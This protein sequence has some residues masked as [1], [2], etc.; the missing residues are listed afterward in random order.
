MRTVSMAAC[1]GMLWVILGGGVYASDS[2]QYWNA[3]AFDYTMNENTAVRISSEQRWLD[4]MSYFGLY[5]VMV[6]PSVK[7]TKQVS[8]G[9]GYRL[10]RSEKD[11][12]W[13]TENRLLVPLT[14][15]W[16]FQGWTVQWRNQL[17]YRDLQ[18]RDRWRIRERIAINRPV[19]IGRLEVRPFVFEELFYDLT[20]GQRNQNRAAVGVGLPLSRNM[21]VNLF[22][23]SRADR[24]AFDWSSIQ[25]LG[26]EW[27]FKF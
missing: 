18:I 14:S 24:G 1:A 4:G 3:L 9:A 12:L 7:L 20:L 11:E 5:N 25:A 15:M 8:L 21:E 19:L 2:W 23:I 16:S 27:V 13:A 26:T 17:E 10:E 6:V 22:Y